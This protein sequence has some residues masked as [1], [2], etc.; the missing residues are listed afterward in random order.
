[1]YILRN[2]DGHYYKVVETIYGGMRFFLTD[3][4]HATTL[5]QIK[6]MRA[7]NVL[8]SNKTSVGEVVYAEMV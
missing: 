7:L 1:M 5:N 4:E 6:A 3:K 2:N 8:N